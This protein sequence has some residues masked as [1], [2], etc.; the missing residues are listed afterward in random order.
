MNSLLEI[1]VLGLYVPIILF[2]GASCW[3]FLKRLIIPAILA[4]RLN[5]EHYA[6]GLSA[7]FALAAHFA[8]SVYYGVARWFGMWD[9]LNSQLLLIGAWKLLILSSC[10]FAVAAL[11]SAENNFANVR[12][13]TMY[14][15][16]TWLFG[17]LA[18]LT[19]I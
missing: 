9:L 7:V 14:A 17:A 5:V 4:R 3:L 13:V 12:R 6:I 19:V 16:L 10:I 2:S 1:A 8:E 18:A 11:N 15:F